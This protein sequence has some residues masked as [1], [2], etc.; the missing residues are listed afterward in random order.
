LSFTGFGL[1]HSFSMTFSALG[2]RLFYSDA[3]KLIRGTVQSILSLHNKP[4]PSHP[5]NENI[6]SPDFCFRFLLGI[7]PQKWDVVQQ[8]EEEQVKEKH[9]YPRLGGGGGK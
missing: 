6:S 1:H 2:F 3:D 9:P 5:I 4:L 8:E 7:C